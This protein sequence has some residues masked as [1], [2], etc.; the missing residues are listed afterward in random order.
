M[1]APL[2]AVGLLDASPGVAALKERLQSFMDSN[3]YPNESVYESQIAELG[4]AQLPII[5]ELKAKA[6]DEG[7]W[8]LFLPDAEIGSGLTNREYG[9]LCEIMGRSEMAPECFNCS[10]PDTGN[11]EVLAQ[12]GTPEQKETW[13]GPLLAGKIRSGIS[14]TEPDV[15]SSDATNMQATITEDGDDYIIHGRKWFTSGAGSPAC[16]V[17]IMMGLSNP[18]NDRHQRHSMILV[19]MDSPGLTVERMLPVFGWNEAPHG[20]AEITYDY[21]RVPKLNMILGAGRGFEIAQARLGPGRIHH[22]MRLIG[23]AERAYEAMCK[24]ANARIAF[25]KPLSE[26]GGLRQEI[27]RSR[28]EIDQARLLVLHTAHQIDTVGVKAARIEVSM[29]KVAAIQMACRVID[30]AIQVHGAA[31]VTNDFSL[32]RAYARARALRFADGPD[33]VHLESIAKRELRRFN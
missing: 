7:L 10:A 17:L 9:L 11:I 4:F 3:I 18:E 19:P 22:C 28:I 16:K 23:Q 6:R 32:A 5:E 27:A 14:M 13:L 20:H 25:G 26:Q 29:I 8:N 24:R 31:G 2:N 33:E 30:R 1:D 15:A 21:V 12:F